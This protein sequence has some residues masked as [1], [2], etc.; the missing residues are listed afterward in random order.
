MSIIRLSLLEDGLYAPD[1]NGAIAED[2]LSSFSRARGRDRR[3]MGRMDPIPRGSFPNANHGL[4]R[5]LEK[6]LEV[7]AAAL[8]DSEEDA[9]LV[10]LVHGFQFD[11]GR[12]HFAPPH[13]PKAENPHSRLYHFERH[14]LET[15]MRHHSTSW[16]LGLG[17][18]NAD[19]GR[20]GVAIGFAWDSAPGIWESFLGQGLNPYVVAYHFAESHAAWHLVALIEALTL[21]RPGRRIDLFCHSLGSRVVVR[22]LAQA[23]DEELTGATA[24]ACARVIDAIDR[25]VILAGAER[26]LEA[27]LMMR[28]LNR[29]VTGTDR[30]AAIF[31]RIPAF[32]NV[33][34]R[35]NDVL[36][37]LGENFGP[38][39]RGS[40]QVI[41]HNGLETRDPAWL[42]LQLD[43]PAVAFWFRER[44]YTVSGDNE[45]SVFAVLDHWIH[46]TWPD[47]MRVYHD[48]LRDRGRWRIAD[49]K[50]AAP[51]LFDRRR[52]IRSPGAVL[53]ESRLTV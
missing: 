24:G 47:N 26:V 12:A 35:E 27:Q 10:V 23:A 48:I 36:D 41:G 46:F 38:E 33:V 20:A 43:D 45:S 52:L 7:E 39:G 40:K 21:L 37:I 51:E 14:R 11:P 49:L 17:V 53:H 34:S 42:D 8:P 22:A 3:G 2:A 19:S 6:S 15:E 5:Y 18:E 29:G 9:P 32:Y 50:A 31:P 44:G 1:H 13:H 28:R 4:R 25:V 30:S 16:P